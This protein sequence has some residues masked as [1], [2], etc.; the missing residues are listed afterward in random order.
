MSCTEN[1]IDLEELRE[2]ARYIPNFAEPTDSEQRFPDLRITQDGFLV[3]LTV[4][5][6]LVNPPYLLGTEYPQLIILPSGF[7][8]DGSLSC[9]LDGV[10][11]IS[12]SKPIK[13]EFPNVYNV[14]VEPPVPVKTGDYIAVHQPRTAAVRIRFVRVPPATPQQI[15]NSDSLPLHPL[16]HLHIA[17]PGGELVKDTTVIPSATLTSKQ[18]G[19]SSGPNVGA[20]AGGVTVAVLVAALCITATAVAAVLCGRRKF[21][22]AKVQTEGTTNPVY[23]TNCELCLPPFL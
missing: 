20:I 12:I 1:F 13:T 10:S 17:S 7:T 11:C 9:S 21:A 4:T 19:N 18:D 3:Q 14:T 6:E 5:A 16:V 8:S 15:Y 23:G 2:K 22:P